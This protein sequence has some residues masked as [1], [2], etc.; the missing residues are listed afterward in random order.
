MFCEDLLLI[1]VDRPRFD[2]DIFFR[3]GASRPLW[4]FRAVRLMEYRVTCAPREASLNPLHPC[5]LTKF[6]DGVISVNPGQWRAARRDVA[7][8]RH[9]ALDDMQI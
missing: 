4:R 3:N 7:V 1:V 5:T 9:R 6:H 2:D 8:S